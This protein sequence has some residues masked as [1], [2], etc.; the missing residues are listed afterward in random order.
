MP[1]AVIEGLS[2]KFVV[3]PGQGLYLGRMN[4][5]FRNATRVWLVCAALLCSVVCL[6]SAYALQGNNNGNNNNNLGG[7]FGFGFGTVGGVFVDPSN[8]VKAAPAT[9]SGEVRRQIEAAVACEGDALRTT[10]KLRKL[11]LRKLQESLERSLT[12]NA[13][14]PPEVAF[15]AG[16]Q[17]IEYVFVNRAERDIVL[18][19]PGEGWEVD[20]AGNVV[21]VTTGCPV[22]RLEDFLVALRSVE[23]AR[24]VDGGIS[25]SI[26]PTTE[27]SAALAKLLKQMK[28][29][30]PEAATTI[31]ETCG[32][33]AITLT[34]IPG[35]SRYAQVLVAADYKLKRLSMG[36]DKAPIADMPSYL[37]IAQRKDSQRAAAPRF[38]ME[39]SYQPLARTED[40]LTWQLRGSGVKTL[41]ED[42]RLSE[43]GQ[44]I[45]TRSG[46]ALAD[47]WAETMTE[48]FD[49]LAQKEPAFRELRNLMDM[50]VVAALIA[51]ERMWDKAGFD[52]GL[53]TDA[54][55]LPTPEYHVPQTVPTQCSFVRLASSWLVTASG[56]VDVNPWSVVKNNQIDSSLEQLRASLE[57]PAPGLWWN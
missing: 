24:Q 18:A 52:A 25:C 8:I 15:M 56:G 42:G 23:S 20:A 39:C 10:T 57:G 33:Q 43:S 48:Q 47:K 4:M 21:G 36:F 49:S 41:V 28:E 13:P 26:N 3:G 35:A 12:E 11:S 40:G 44:R 2:A 14:L 38:W 45:A 31:E 46:N 29:F 6:P 53:L 27:G 16:L 22:I 37:E 7:L 54:S 19:G 55:R 9:I 17:R 5:S 50:S 1:R 34:G 30:R 51:E 32:P